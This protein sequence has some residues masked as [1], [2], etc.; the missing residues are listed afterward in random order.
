MFS[1][2]RG[3][4]QVEAYSD[5]DWSGDRATRRSVSAG[6]VH[7]RQALSGN[8]GKNPT[9]GV[10]V[11]CGTSEPLFILAHRLRCWEGQGKAKHV[12]V[13][14]QQK[15]RQECKVNDSLRW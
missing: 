14:R 9:G 4:P 1:W 8:T 2:Q 10:V 13:H 12:D 15:L 6:C 7:A 5:V 3:G 11:V